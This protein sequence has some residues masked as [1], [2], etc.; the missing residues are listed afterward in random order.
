VR[1]AA[2]D[3]SAARTRA[4]VAMMQSAARMTARELPLTL[5]GPPALAAATIGF[6]AA[7][8]FA[9]GVHEFASAPRRDAVQAAPGS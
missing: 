8:P 7:V 9:A 5:E 3:A 1:R 2:A 4:I 6:G